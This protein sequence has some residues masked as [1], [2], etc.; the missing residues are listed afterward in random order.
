MQ[1]CAQRFGCVSRALHCYGSIETR[2]NHLAA[3]ATASATCQIQIQVAKSKATSIFEDHLLF[4]Q[5]HLMF[6]RDSLQ[7]LLSGEPEVSLAAVGAGVRRT[8][9]KVRPDN[10]KDCKRLHADTTD[11]SKMKYI[12]YIYKYKHIQQALQVRR[13]L[14]TAISAAGNLPAFAADRRKRTT[15]FLRSIGVY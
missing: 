11:R 3:L 7:P 2:S 15:W 13:A 5:R 14:S 4:E 6:A 10:T 1:H 9:T 8:S 12:I